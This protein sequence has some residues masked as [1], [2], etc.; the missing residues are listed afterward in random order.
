MQPNTQS[1]QPGAFLTARIIHLALAA[2]VLLFLV[3]AWFVGPAA[4][5]PAAGLDTLVT[6]LPLGCLGLF[7]GAIVLARRLPSRS[8]AQTADE[9]WAANLPT[10]IV[11]WAMLE[12]AGLL[13]AV[14]FFMT[15]HRAAALWAVIAVLLLLWHAPGRMAS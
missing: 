9:W 11:T 12:G 6:V 2:C 3:V 15:G 1:G 14:T 8:P 7:L 4:G 10:A 13:A 5:A